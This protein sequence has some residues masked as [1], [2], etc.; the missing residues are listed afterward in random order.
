GALRLGLTVVQVS[1]LYLGQDLIRVLEDAGPRGLVTLEIL[2]PN[3]A[4]IAG[5]VEVPIVWVAQLREFYPRRTRL[6]VNLVLRRQQRS[7][8]VPTGPR[9]RRWRDAVRDRGPFP[10]ATGDP[11]T[12]IAVLQ[13]TGGTTGRPKA[14]MLSH[15]NLVANALQCRAWF[16]TDPGTATVLA[17]IPFFHIYGMTVALNY[18]ML[19]GATIVLET[20]PDPSEILRLIH[21][22]RPTEFPGVPALYQAI[23]HHPKVQRYDIRS[24][25]VCLSG[26][27][28]LPMEVATTF[29]RLTGGHLIEGYGLTEASPV[30]HANP[31][32]GERRVGTIGLP[33][34]NTD[35][36]VVDLE[37]GT[38]TLGVGE[39]GE[40]LVRGP[41][42]MLGYYRQP[43]ETAD[44]LRD[45][46]LRTGDVASIDADGYAT[47][48]DRKK[49]LI[50]V[51]GF[52]VYPREVEDVLYQ[53]ASVAEAA[54]IGV[55]DEALGEVV[56]A[57]VVLKKGTTASAE[58]LI[59]HVRERIAHYKAPRSIEFRTELPRSG[60]LKVLRRVLRQDGAGPATTR[61]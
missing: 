27:A 21:R 40:L 45:G 33:F 15:R 41:Q 47:I 26:S 6:F 46:W 57:F 1:P 34:P 18:P 35:Q 39:A 9:I 12:E 17:A 4:K 60:A 43:A 16:R 29:E 32:R 22:Y 20:R 19:D 28:P 54:V 7:T 53:H 59:Q 14:A 25:R 42:V 50:D 49:D 31:I 38:R 52:K 10:E 37:T 48:V 3:L 55:P 56:K 61:D 8:A 24:I 36:R 44:V 30:T 23:N 51:G 58:E 11:A 2:Y 13:Y 5:T